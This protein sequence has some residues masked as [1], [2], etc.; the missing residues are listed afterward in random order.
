MTHFR[1]L[2]DRYTLQKILRSSRGGTVLRATDNRTG[3]EVAVKLITVASPQLLVQKAPEL[4]KLGAVLESLREPSLPAVTDAGLATDGSAFLVMELLDGKTL[5]ALSGPPQRLL[6]LLAQ[7]L[8][9]L[10]ALARRGV[11]HRNLAPDNFLVVGALPAEQIKILGLG[12]GLFRAPEGEPADPRAD[13]LAFAQTACRVLGITVASDDP[14]SAQMP[15]ALSLELE[16]SELFRQTLERCLRRDPAGRPSHQEIRDAF[17]RAL[18]AH[19]VPPPPAPLPPPEPAAPEP[20]PGEGLELLP[21][22]DDDVLDA[23]ASAPPAPAAPTADPP[24]GRVVP[25]RGAGSASVAPPPP[26][27]NPLLRPGVLLALAAALILAAAGTFWWLGRN[28][29]PPDTPRVA[30]PEIPPPPRRPAA[31]VLAEAEAAMADER[32]ESALQA[33]GSLNAADQRNLS[34]AG[35]RALSATQEAL[36]RIGADRL[37]DTLA[38]GLKK[39]DLE[40]LR[41]A[42]WAADAQGE[43]SLPEPIRADLARGR[44]LLDRYAAIEQAAARQADTEVLE[45]FAALE[46]DFPGVSDPQGFREQAASALEAQAESLARDGKYDEAVV[47]LDPVLRYWPQRQSARERSDLYLKARQE[48]AAQEELLATTLPAAERRRKPDEGLARMEGVVPVPHLAA[49]LANFRKRLQDQL[50]VLDRQ[51]PQIEDR[52]L[53]LE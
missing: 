33:L 6:G 23:L 45:I 2:T 7:A 24:S 32:W 51:P 14:P 19:L 50:A 4:E 28:T 9:G 20:L 49:Q 1:E 36:A 53:V 25:F 15:F 3:Q 13:L 18:G 17:R 52:E 22:V 12:S 11:A 43:A 27:R 40:K 5:D 44:S 16:N 10:E 30:A 29:A 38:Q 37:P 21:S 42:V 39:A 31:E 26:K 34:P 46:K 48:T 47:R 41:F 35:C 8:D